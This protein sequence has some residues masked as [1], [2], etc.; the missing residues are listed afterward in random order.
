MA[1][2][3]YLPETQKVVTA[4]TD[5][6]Q[7][8]QIYSN[9][10]VTNSSLFIN[11][12][13]ITKHSPLTYFEVNQNIVDA[14]EEKI[15][16]DQDKTLVRVSEVLKWNDSKLRDPDPI[17]RQK[18]KSFEGA[19]ISANI[20]PALV[21]E[22]TIA[23]ETV[24]DK[25]KK[26]KSDYRKKRENQG[27]G[28]ICEETNQQIIEKEKIHIHHD[29]RVADYPELAAEESTLNA[30]GSEKHHFRHKDDNKLI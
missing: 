10:K 15:L 1:K 13:E 22:R 25:S 7:I 5:G 29:P 26:A 18:A 12:N 2:I 24:E 28:T 14:P 9:T 16:F 23:S 19:I 21:N 30:I 27:L 4:L 17:V 6:P 8:I 3:E 20:Q 11:V